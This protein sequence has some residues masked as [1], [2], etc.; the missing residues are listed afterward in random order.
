MQRVVRTLKTDIKTSNIQYVSKKYFNLEF[1]NVIFLETANKL[2]FYMKHVCVYMYAR[3]I[4]KNT[5][6]EILLESSIH[7]GSSL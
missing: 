2:Q 3:H 1:I 4:H 7:T 5:E 6:P